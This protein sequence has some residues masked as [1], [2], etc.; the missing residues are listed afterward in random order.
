MGLQVYQTMDEMRAVSLDDLKQWILL[1]H[2]EYSY[3][4]GWLMPV[5]EKIESLGHKTIIGYDRDLTGHYCNIMTGL[6]L[7]D[8]G[9][10][11]AIGQGKN[12]MEAIYNAVIEHIKWRNENK[13]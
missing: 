6:K 8:D 5:V 2:A 4:W 1:E 3:N 7:T 11:K 9:P 12:K 10:T 13:I